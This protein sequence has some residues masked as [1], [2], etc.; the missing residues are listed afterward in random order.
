MQSRS[1]RLRQEAMDDP[2]MEVDEDDDESDEAIEE[3]KFVMAI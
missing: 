3:G 2:D 1:D